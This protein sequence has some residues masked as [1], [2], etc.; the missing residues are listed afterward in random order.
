M[1]IFRTKTA[2]ARRKR[3]VLSAGLIYYTML[4]KKYYF[5]NKKTVKIKKILEFFRIFGRFAKSMAYNEAV[6]A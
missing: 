5:V 4:N 6:N 1:L 3:G 2:T